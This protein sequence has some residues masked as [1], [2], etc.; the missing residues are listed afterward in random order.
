[1]RG[2]S[3]E[4]ARRIPDGQLPYIRPHK[5]NGTSQSHLSRLPAQREK[6]N[7]HTTRKAHQVIPQQMKVRISHTQRLVNS[8]HVRDSESECPRAGVYQKERSR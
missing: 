5:K 3:K 8:T 6:R 2:R 7:T 4:R 1:M